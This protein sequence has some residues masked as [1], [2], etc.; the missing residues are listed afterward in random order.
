MPGTTPIYGFPYPCANENVNFTDF[1]ALGNAIDSKL[2]QV[3]ADADHAVGR[4]NVSQNGSTQAGIAV[5]VDTVL[6]NPTAQYVVPESGVYLVMVDVLTVAVT[7]ITSAR[8]RVR[9]NGVAAFGR[10]FNYE[11]GGFAPSLFWQIP[12]GPLV[13][14]AGD[15]IS[16]T[17][18]YQG[19]GTATVQIFLSARQAIRIA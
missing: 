3:D 9:L 15:T 2:L 10:T 12:S 5:G 17:Y 19:T 18:L 4:Y 6:T 13:A 7:T 16:C 14:A 8:V 11:V 1:T